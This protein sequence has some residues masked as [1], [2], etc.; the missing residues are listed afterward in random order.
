[1]CQLGRC[2]KVLLLAGAGCNGEKRFEQV[3]QYR[4]Q[5]GQLLADRR[6]MCKTGCEMPWSEFSQEKVVEMCEEWRR[7]IQDRE[8]RSRKP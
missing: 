7:R 8:F 1:M 3:L 4:Q 5:T 2:P 6:M